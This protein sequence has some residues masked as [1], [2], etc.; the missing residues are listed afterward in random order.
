MELLVMTLIWFLSAL[1]STNAVPLTP[2]GVINF[3]SGGIIM[4]GIMFGRVF[5]EEKPSE[6]PRTTFSPPLMVENVPISFGEGDQVIPVENRNTELTPEIAVK[7]IKDTSSTEG[8]GVPLDLV[9]FPDETTGTS[10]SPV[11]AVAVTDEE[12]SGGDGGFLFPSVIRVNM[13]EPEK[14]PSLISGIVKAGKEIC[15]P[16]HGTIEVNG[17]CTRF[18]ARN[19]CP[20]GEWFVEK[21]ENGGECVPRPCPFGQLQFRGTCVNVADDTVCRDGQMLYVE[22]S[23]YVHC[24]CLP[25]FIYDPWSGKCFAQGDQGNCNFGE[26][27]YVGEDGIVKCKRNRCLMDGFVFS[28]GRCFRKQYRGYCE[29][30]LLITHLRNMTAECVAIAEHSIF[31]L[32]T[33]RS[34]TGGS[35]R[36]YTGKCRD[37]FRVPS[38]SSYPTLYG[39]CP[40]NFVKDSRG[41]CR[42]M[43][44]LLG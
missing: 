23:G 38:V 2:G 39:G 32:P 18:L 22:F 3:K 36:D 11:A 44:R 13:D 15:G 41:T 4:P 28:S 25:N 24:D 1:T 35:L 7:D 19:E 27:V 30:N 37:A 33:M 40:G 10:S 12:G 31:D 26:Q 29:E 16:Q 21:N 42:K 20:D 6:T 34:C 43:N 17:T 5:I 8:S 9:H 14:S